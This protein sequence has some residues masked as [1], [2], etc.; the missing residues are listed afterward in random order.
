MTKEYIPVPLQI[1]MKECKRL[2]TYAES[3]SMQCIH[4]SRALLH[5]AVSLVD[6]DNWGPDELWKNQEIQR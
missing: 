3:L 6:S 4:I 1:T 2:V 5:L